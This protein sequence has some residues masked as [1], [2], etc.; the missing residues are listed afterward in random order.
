MN[1]TH[2]SDTRQDIEMDVDAAVVDGSS[3]L[4]EFIASS[5]DCGKVL[6][7]MKWLLWFGGGVAWADV[8]PFVHE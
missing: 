8:Y 6:L 3:F 1:K 7:V 2:G 4:L 5:H